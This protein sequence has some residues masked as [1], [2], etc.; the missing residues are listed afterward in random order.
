[1][2]PVKENEMKASLV[3]IGGGGSGLAAAVAA[4]E[5]GL[6][7][8]IV[9]DKRGLGG[10]SAMSLGIFGAESPAQKRALIESNRNDLFMTAMDFA[11]W[12]TN[13]RIIRAFIDK[14]GD[15]IRWLEEKG[16]V[17]EVEALYPG[18][19]PP[20]WHV[21]HGYGSA[22]VKTLIGECHKLG[23]KLMPHN[24]ALQIIRDKKG[25]VTGVL[26]E[27]K[28]EQYVIKTG[29]AI[30]ASGGYSGNKSM[31]KKY[32]RGYHQ[33]MIRAGLSL[34]GD[35][36]KMATEIGAATEGLGTLIVSGPGVP[37]TEI[38][39]HES[40]KPELSLPLMAVAQEPNTLWVNKR[41]ERYVNEATGCNHFESAMAVLRQ[42]DVTTYTLM[43]SSIVQHKIDR[44]LVI[45]MLPNEKQQRNGVPALENGLK[46]ESEKGWVKIAKSWDKIAEWIGT[47]PGTLNTTV[48]EYNSACDKGFD[49][50]FAKKR[51]YLLPLRKPPFYAIRAHLIYV[52]TIGGIKIDEKMQ[53]LDNSD[54]VIGGLYAAG[55]VTGGWEPEAYCAVLS[56]SAFGFAINSGRIAG[57]NAAGKFKKAS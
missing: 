24:S 26:A 9:L 51:E 25:N 36:F 7:N 42:P 14:S 48:D 50:L 49:P 3:I 31:M 23:V 41:G 6:K 13:P 39:K 27:N 29:A 11:H 45:G 57:E 35:G 53:V 54:K 52:D 1:M 20:T 12:K 40:G 19:A 8:I 17:F 21:P 34:T 56:G 38:L 46:K 33:N 22:L 4:A 15:T 18:Q 32:F 16:L 10:T 47:D 55:V 44:G 2:K 28:T 30:I 5:K 37:L 43:D